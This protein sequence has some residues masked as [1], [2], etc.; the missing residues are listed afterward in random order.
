MLNIVKR[1]PWP[2]LFNL[3]LAMLLGY[4]LMQLFLPSPLHPAPSS[5]RSSASS[6]LVPDSATAPQALNIHTVLQAHLFGQAGASKP[7]ETVENT[8]LDAPETRLQLTLQGTLLSDNSRYSKAIIAPANGKGEEYEIGKLLPGGAKL[9]DIHS[10]KVILQRQRQ[11]ETLSLVNEKA[12]TGVKMTHQKNPALPSA[13]SSPNPGL[14]QSLRQYRQRI[15]DNPGVM[16]DLIRVQPAK[17]QGQFVGYSL[18][19]GRNQKLFKESG[20]QKGDILTHLNGTHL[21]SPIKGL[22]ALQT[23]A[24]AEFL[25]LQVLRN[26]T[27]MQFSFSLR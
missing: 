17:R 18:S 12:K 21:D 22:T 16:R 11:L 7:T 6:A 13:V 3:P 24:S 25:D 1:I 15:M 10:N 26:G 5:S 23:L 27:S 9:H 2:G 19:P 20:L 14:S 4:A 8:T